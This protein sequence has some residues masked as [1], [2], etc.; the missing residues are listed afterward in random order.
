MLCAASVPSSLAYVEVLRAEVIFVAAPTHPLASERPISVERLAEF[1]G[2][3]PNI[4]GYTASAFLGR[5]A[6]ADTLDAY[7]ANDFEALMPL[8]RAGHASR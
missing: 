7:T 3:G 5:A 4:P 8:V 6:A 1:P 2:A